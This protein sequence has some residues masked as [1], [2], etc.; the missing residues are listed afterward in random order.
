MRCRA[1]TSHSGYLRGPKTW[2]GT[3]INTHVPDVPRRLPRNHP[4]GDKKKRHPRKRR[5][6]RGSQK[7][8]LVEFALKNLRKRKGLGILSYKYKRSG[9]ARSVWI[10]EHSHR[11]LAPNVV[12]FTT[13]CALTRPPGHLQ[14]GAGGPVCGTCRCVVRSVGEVFGA[15][16]DQAKSGRNADASGQIPTDRTPHK[17]SHR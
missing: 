17:T 3:H 13:P 5:R 8:V 9:E 7:L 14:A 15:G 12:L 10:G 6:T 2:F 1:H 4:T 11:S 16:N